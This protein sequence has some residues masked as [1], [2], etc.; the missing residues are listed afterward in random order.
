MNTLFR[1]LIASILLIQGGQAE[2]QNPAPPL[3]TRQIIEQPNV[4]IASRLLPDDEMVLVERAGFETRF[5]DE[6]VLDVQEDLDLR[7][8]KSDLIMVADCVAAEG[9]LINNDSYVRSKVTFLP[10]LV[11]KDSAQVTSEPGGLVPVFHGGGDVRIKGVLVRAGYFY[12]YKPG[13]RYLMFLRSVSKDNNATFGLQMAVSP[14]N[15]LSPMELSTGRAFPDSSRLFGLD[16]DF[17]MR[18]LRRRLTSKV[19]L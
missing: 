8:S 2:T 17:V 9:F 13:A 5:V 11:L 16:L 15:K 19:V 14:D 7:A 4:P 12:V 18:E 6:T 1:I 10:V 3:K